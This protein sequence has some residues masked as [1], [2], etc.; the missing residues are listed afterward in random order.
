MA[1]FGCLDQGLDPL[2]V[3]RSDV[4]GLLPAVLPAGIVDLGRTSGQQFRLHHKAVGMTPNRECGFDEA[5]IGD[6]QRFEFHEVDLLYLA[7]VAP[8]DEERHRAAQE[9]YCSAGRPAE[10]F[11]AIFLAA[12]EGDFR[13]V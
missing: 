2:A 8:V 12:S 4:E 7:Q 1:P 6:L 5:V 9:G 11:Q 10:I 3:F 13:I